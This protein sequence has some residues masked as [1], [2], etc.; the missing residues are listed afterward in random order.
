MIV[1]SNG[2]LIVPESGDA[3][4]KLNPREKTLYLFFLRH[5]EGIAP[6]ALVGHRNELLWIYKTFT[7]FDDEIAIEGSIDSLL[8]EDKKALYTNVSRINS[9]IKT[10]IGEITSKPYMLRFIYRTGLYQID[11]ASESIRWDINL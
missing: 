3:Q 8:E 10:K 9:K 4:I 2:V 6:D 7:I 11:V 1:D 5:P